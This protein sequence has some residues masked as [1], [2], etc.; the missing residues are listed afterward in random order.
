M[1]FILVEFP[2]ISIRWGFFRF[3]FDVNFERE[4]V[5][6]YCS[7]AF[8]VKRFLLEWDTCPPPPACSSARVGA[9]KLWVISWQINLSW[10]LFNPRTGSGSGIAG[11]LVGTFSKGTLFC[12]LPIIL[13]RFI[14]G[15]KTYPSTPTRSSSSDV[16]QKLGRYRWHITLHEYQV[17]QRPLARLRLRI[18][19]ETSPKTY[20]FPTKK[21]TNIFSNH[22]NT[23]RKILQNSINVLSHVKCNKLQKT[24]RV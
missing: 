24:N 9:K 8:I 14:L 1:K 5:V 10:V 18:W 16:S 13:R 22:K 12:P 7:W 20:S 2:T 11:A 19:W 21:P 17:S 3:D 15:F 4:V 6:R 23:E